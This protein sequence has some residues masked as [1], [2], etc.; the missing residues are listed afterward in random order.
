MQPNTWTVRGSGS[1]S[2]PPPPANSRRGRRGWWRS[3]ARPG[4][5]RAMTAR[6][7]GLRRCR[8]P[9]PARP[10]GPSPLRP[11]HLSA[12]S[13]AAHPCRSTPASAPPTLSVLTSSTGEGAGDVSGQPHASRTGSRPAQD[14]EHQRRGPARQPERRAVGAGRDE[15]GPSR[16]RS[17]RH[18]PAAPRRRHVVSPRPRPAACARRRLPLPAAR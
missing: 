7:L 2:A 13:G 14:P 1:V 15:A 3:R 12:R 10:R 6:G 16:R 8:L 11:P 9:L 18:P 5:P 4:T 17:P